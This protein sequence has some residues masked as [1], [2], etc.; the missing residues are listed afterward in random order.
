MK[1]QNDTIAKVI[2]LESS[3]NL[4]E[5]VK[6]LAEMLPNDLWKGFKFET[7]TVITWSNPIIWRDIY[8]PPVTPYYPTTPWIT[9]QADK[10]YKLCSGV[11]NVQI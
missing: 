6:A 10:N 3:E 9:W 11:Y 7:N 1:I 4:G 5:L 8:V 2:K